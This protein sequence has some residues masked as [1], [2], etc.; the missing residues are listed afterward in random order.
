[1][2][3]N[4]KNTVAIPA[5]L[6]LWLSFSS[7]LHAEPLNTFC[8][9]GSCLWE[10]ILSEEVILEGDLETGYLLLKRSVQFT[11][12]HQGDYPD[13]FTAAPQIL[14]YSGKKMNKYIHLT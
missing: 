2:S 11:T 9:M 8:K 3:M 4:K 10:E 14:L 7:T 1:M 12:N 13:Y 6:A 5:A